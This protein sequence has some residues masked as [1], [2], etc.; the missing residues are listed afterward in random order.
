MI[1]S[2]KGVPLRGQAGFFGGDVAGGGGG[3]PRRVALANITTQSMFANINF[4]T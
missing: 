4:N 3:E 2:I 1:A